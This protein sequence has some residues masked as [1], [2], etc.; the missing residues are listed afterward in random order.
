MEHTPH[1]VAVGGGGLEA[2]QLKTDLDAIR[3]SILE[4]NARVMTGQET[5]MPPGYM[6]GHGVCAVMVVLTKM[7]TTGLLWQCLL[8]FLFELPSMLWH[9]P[10]M[11]W[12][13]ADQR[14]IWTKSSSEPV[15]LRYPCDGIHT[16][17]GGGRQH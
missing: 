7:C 3:D 11:S 13:V 12:L 5:G 17:A 9:H 10:T 14:M 8:C 6:Y 1:V 2:R 16:M 4:T 15:C